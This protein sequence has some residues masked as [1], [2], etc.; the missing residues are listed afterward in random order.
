[1]QLNK[2]TLQLNRKYNLTYGF[3]Q[4]MFICGDNSTL[5]SRHDEDC[6]SIGIGPEFGEV[7]LLYQCVSSTFSRPYQCVAVE[8]DS[9]S[10]HVRRFFGRVNSSQSLTGL[11]SHC[12]TSGS[13]TTTA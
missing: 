7:C 4:E 3:R 9:V 8:P 10:M 11:A 1:M 5:L 13:R 2:N 6:G 12:G